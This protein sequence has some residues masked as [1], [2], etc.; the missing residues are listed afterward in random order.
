MFVTSAF[1]SLW[2]LTIVGIFIKRYSYILV[3]YIIAEN[4]KIKTL[5]AINLS[6]KMMDGHKWECFKLELSY[7]GWLI[8]GIE[9]NPTILIGILSEE[10]N[11]LFL[12]LSS[13]LITVSFSEDVNT[14]EE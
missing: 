7:I 9:S 12:M 10:F 11:R 8:L 13:D 3:P 1:Y 2:C 14:S 5:D 4:P 6:R